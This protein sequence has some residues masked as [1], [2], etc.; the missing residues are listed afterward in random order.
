[1]SSYSKKVVTCKIASN[2]DADEYKTDFASTNVD[3]TIFGP[4]EVLEE[5]T[6]SNISV[7]ADFNGLLDDVSSTVSLQ[8]PL[9]ITLTN[10]FSECWVY[11]SYTATVT[12]SKK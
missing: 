12:V 3:V 2:H 4:E 7:I 9:S 1:M 6:A 11:G 5:L 10:N 8:V